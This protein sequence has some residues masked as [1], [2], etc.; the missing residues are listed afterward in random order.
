MHGWE[1]WI[2]S[3]FSF[4]RRCHDEQPT[5]E[6]APAM[7]REQPNESKFKKCARAQQGRKLSAL[8]RVQLVDGNKGASRGVSA[9]KSDVRKKKREMCELLEG[10]RG[11]W[12]S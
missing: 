10:T 9:S 12:F 2:S 7:D 4:D 11:W 5:V 6:F 8:K 3:F 1:V